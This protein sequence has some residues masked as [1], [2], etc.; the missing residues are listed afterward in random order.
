MD[1]QDSHLAQGTAQTQ[2]LKAQS[3]RQTLASTG[4]PEF[5]ARESSL[6]SSADSPSSSVALVTLFYKKTPDQR[7]SDPTIL[8]PQ[9]ER[10]KLVADTAQVGFVYHKPGNGQVLST[11]CFLSS[12]S[13]LPSS[14]RLLSTHLSSH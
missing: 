2:F 12:G 10:I 13:E 8:S 3:P 11:C 5:S 9:A 1:I 4:D 14:P 6:K 7:S